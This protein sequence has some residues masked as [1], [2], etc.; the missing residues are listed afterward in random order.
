MHRTAHCTVLR[1]RGTRRHR[2]HCG[3]RRMADLRGHCP[4]EVAR[5][6]TDL[7]CRIEALRRRQGRSEGLRTLWG[8]SGHPAVPFR[9]GKEFEH[10][11][12]RRM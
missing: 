9:I 1:L 7:C 11:P 5:E 3:D 6:L 2:G 4:K 12:E 10:V 8:P